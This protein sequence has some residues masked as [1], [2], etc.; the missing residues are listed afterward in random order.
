MGSVKTQ[1][2]KLTPPLHILVLVAGTTDPINADDIGKRAHSYDSEYMYWDNDFTKQIKEFCNEYKNLKLFPFHGWTGDNSIKNREVA[3]AYLV[4]RL[5]GAEGQKA[6]YEE[7]YQNKKI[8]FHL[9]G[10]SHGGNVIN[11]MTKQMDKLGDK[12]P[13]TWKVK[14]ITY[15]STPFFNKIHQVKVTDKTFHKDVEIL[16]LFNDYD[17]TQRMLAD[18]SMEPLAGAIHSIDTK[19]LFKAIESL[20][21][22]I[23]DTPFEN[24]EEWHVGFSVKSTVQ[25]SSVM[26]HDNG[27]ELYKK[28]Q[29]ILKKF[30]A[31]LFQILEIIKTLNTKFV[32]QVDKKIL[33]KDGK[34]LDNKRQMLSDDVYKEFQQIFKGLQDDVN[35]VTKQLNDTVRDNNN[36]KFSKITYL[37]TLFKS[38]NFIIHVNNLLDINAKTLTSV[39]TPSIWTLLVQILK[40]NINDFDNTYQKPED[41]KQFKGINIKI[42]D[43]VDVTER[44]LYNGSQG[45]ENYKKFVKYIE[46]IETEYD[47]NP[48]EK[49]LLDLLFTLIAQDSSAY[50]LI[51]EITSYGNMLDNIEYVATG[52]LDTQ[53]KQI[54]HTLENL[55]VVF[56]SRRFSTSLPRKSRQRGPT[57]YYDSLED[58]KHTFSKEDII[59]NNDT[60]S[61][62]DV[63][64]RGSLMYLL[65]ESHST[66]RRILHTE[67]KEFLIRLGA[68]K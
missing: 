67:V 46:D 24:L 35:I 44:D 10:H 66:S 16:S 51:K 12:W 30:N 2:A 8:I 59:K 27:L 11:E 53:L 17:L 15:L 58:E 48:S 25:K 64:K 55:E 56:D 20:N 40:E 60:N 54:R 28:T 31:V 3:G 47:S 33:D 13:E 36:E 50:A 1:T 41:G 26:S 6:F 18:F 22:A 21:K 19:Y 7:S 43:S 42:N 4:N 29:V 45:S 23:K 68:K 37:D 32:F 52:E 9:L 62:N 63:M 61:H 14:S 65:Q 49:N 57:L 5:C 39:H 34:A 38:R